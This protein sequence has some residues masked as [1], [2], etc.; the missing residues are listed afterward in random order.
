MRKWIAI[1]AALVLLLG[2]V[3]LGSPYYAIYSFALPPE[4]PIRTNSSPA[5]I[6]R[7]FGR[8]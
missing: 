6:S 4:T 5:S 8:A 3:Y 7:R 1:G 2:G